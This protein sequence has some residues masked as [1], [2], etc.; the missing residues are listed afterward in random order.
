MVWHSHMLNP[1]AYLEDTLRVFLRNLWALGMPWQLVNAAIDT[2]FNYDVDQ[3]VKAQWVARTGRNWSNDEASN[4]KT[5][6]CPF[7]NIPNEIP[8]TSCGEDASHDRKVNEAG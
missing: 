5:V 3:D 4:I 8:W 2:N 1:R 6:S 7:C